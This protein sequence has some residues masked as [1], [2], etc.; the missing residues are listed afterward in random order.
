MWIEKLVQS[1]TRWPCIW[2]AVELSFARA[3]WLLCSKD[4]ASIY[5]VLCSH[6]WY[7]LD[8]SAPI[9]YPGDWIRVV[10]DKLWDINRIKLNCW[11]QRSSEPPLWLADQRRIEEKFLH[12]KR[13]CSYIDARSRKLDVSH[14][15]YPVSLNNSPLIPEC[16][17][18]VRKSQLHEVCLCVSPPVMLQSS[19][20]VIQN[21]LIMIVS[22]S[23]QSNL[24]SYLYLLL[25]AG[26]LDTWA[27]F[28][29]YFCMSLGASF[30]ESRQPC[31]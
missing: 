7:K 16:I 14:L 9:T 1:W 17:P 3:K 22:Q 2:M 5:L 27:A 28:M 6:S 29:S 13:P 23:P 10:V 25:A 20:N 19:P 12:W 11:R 21:K 8:D 15:K 24:L 4:S 30:R 26:T 18:F 31:S